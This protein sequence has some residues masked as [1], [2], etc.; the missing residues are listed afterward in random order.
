[1][2]AAQ[3]TQ[4]ITQNPVVGDLGGGNRNMANGR[5][6]SWWVFPGW[7]AHFFGGIFN[8]KWIF[9]CGGRVLHKLL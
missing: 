9:N 1:M 2:K 6:R 7:V 4:H 3:Q 8:F 5:I